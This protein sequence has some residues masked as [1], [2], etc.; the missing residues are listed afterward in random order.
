MFGVAFGL[1]LICIM[2]YCTFTPHPLPLPHD[3]CFKLLWPSFKQTLTPDRVEQ[4]CRDINERAW[5]E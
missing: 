4:M 3:D 2:A 5:N 1:L